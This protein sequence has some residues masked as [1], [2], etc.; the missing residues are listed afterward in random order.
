MKTLTTTALL[1]LLTMHAAHAADC[2]NATTT[3]DIDE[4]AAQEQKQVEA[5]LN[6][7]YQRVIKKLDKPDADGESYSE[8][9]TSL[10]AAQ[11]AWI[12]F[13]DADC[14]AVYT[15][16]ASG[17]IRTAMF[18]GCMQSH[19]EQRIRELEEYEAD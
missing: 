4:C 15:R 11:R 14:K 17:T 1:I 18:I 19:T 12:K 2:K 6:T 7:V 5:K 16:Y 3:V 10:I 8:M 9:K 13:R